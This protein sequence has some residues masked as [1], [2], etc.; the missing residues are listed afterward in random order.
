MDNPSQFQR[1]LQG[2]LA[3]SEQAVRRLVAYYEPHIRRVIRRRM[4]RQMRG[5][6]DSADFVQM[7]W[8][9]TFRDRRRFNQL[10]RHSDLV[11]FLTTLARNKLVQELRKRMLTQGYDVNRERAIP[12][13][14]ARGLAHPGPSPS[15]WAI[16]REEW[17]RIVGDLPDR[18]R[19]IVWLRMQGSTY[20]EIAEELQLHERTV[21]KIIHRLTP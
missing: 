20:V 21:R 18:E 5:K 11:R 12:S 17:Q 3:G 10:A 15:Q 6:F 13:D 16:A 2:V 8:A 14:N 1:T 19:R 9:S 4:P 7:V